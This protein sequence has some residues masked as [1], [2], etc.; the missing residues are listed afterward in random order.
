MT[1]MSR[2]RAGT[3]LLALTLT[4]ATGAALAAAP[5]RRSDP[6]AARRGSVIGY[7]K[8][9]VLSRRAVA[10]ELAQARIAP[11]D[12]VLG[13]SQVR[14][15]IAVYRVVYR[16]AGPSGT[17]PAS[18]LVAFPTLRSA[19]LGLVDYGHGTTATRA[20]V[21]SAFGLRDGLGIEGRWTAE[22][23]AS[24]GFAV[25]LP[26]YLGMGISRCGRNTRWRARR[27]PRQSTCSGR[28]GHSRASPATGSPV[29]CSS[30]CGW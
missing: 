29:V 5:P 8:I 14:S 3:T 27:F 10:A 20:D 13:A 21:P 30:R 22:L 23:F 16:T 15:G 12:P 25:T 2:V 24:A 18:G 17:V 26:D 1:N 28:L 9:A 7:R 11:G 4:V 6:S 19:R